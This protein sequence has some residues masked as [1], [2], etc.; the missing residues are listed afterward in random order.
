VDGAER[1]QVAAD[2]AQVYERF[3]VPALFG[4]WPERLLEEAGVGAGDRVLDVGCGTGV[5]ARAAAS[6][7]GAT[8][9][10]AGIDPNPGMLSVARR[11]V[12]PVEW[13][14]GAAEELRF[15]DGSFDRVLSQFAL[16]FFEDRV[17][18]LREM[19][20]VLRP[21]GRVAVATWGSLDTTPG[22]AAMVDLLRPLFGEAAADALTAPF[23]LGDPDDLQG[24]LRSE[25]DEVTVASHVGLARFDSIEAWVHT[26]IRGW[27]LADMIDDDQYTLL[28]AEAEHDLAGFI[29][30]S[31]TVEFAAPALIA[32]AVR[33]N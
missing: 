6:T 28:L 8:G 19:G 21:G 4:Q 29:T 22:Y 2:A 31:G 1:G 26:D 33:A 24:L 16:M 9:Y 11:A 14:E 17:A 30:T 7:V 3:F 23:V 25:F 5:L 13:F 32:V 10:V 12:E 27:T 15:E 18:G 20:R